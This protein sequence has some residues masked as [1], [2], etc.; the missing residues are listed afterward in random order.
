MLNVQE[1]ADAASKKSLETVK[2]GEKIVEALELADLEWLKFE[3]FELARAALAKTRPQEAAKMAPP[4]FHPLLAALG[5][6]SPAQYMLHVV[7]E[8]RSSD[9]DQ[10]L[11]VLPFAQVFSLFRYLE[12]W[13][14]KVRRL[15]KEKEEGEKV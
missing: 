9:L 6:L 5:K 2:A 11:L 7:R 15:S 13:V 3:D 10:A 8:I 14:R 12:E 1:E 4:P